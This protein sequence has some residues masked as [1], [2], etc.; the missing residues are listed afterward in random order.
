M[1]YKKVLLLLALFILLVPMYGFNNKNEINI[2]NCHITSESSSDV[3]SKGVLVEKSTNKIICMR[4]DSNQAVEGM[5][6]GNKNDKEPAATESE[7]I[8]E[9][10]RLV[11]DQRAA[12]GL[13]KLTYR[14][15]LQKAANIRAG[16]I[17]NTFSHNRPNGTDFSTVFTQ[18]GVTNYKRLG[19]N[20][21]SGYSSPEAVMNGWMNSEGHKAN[22]LNPDFKGI[23]VGVKKINNNSYAWVQLFITQ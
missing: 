17:V 14:S 11:N 16:E 5:G 7:M 12:L 19:E 23:I 4:V 22:I 15:D 1:R 2:E 10:F 20:I 13:T 9:V 8:D 6:G 18:I 21:A 3:N